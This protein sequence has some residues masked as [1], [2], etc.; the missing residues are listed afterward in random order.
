MDL[1]R[2]NSATQFYW[3]Y[4]FEFLFL[5]DIDICISFLDPQSRCSELI[6]INH[7]RFE[8]LPDIWRSRNDAYILTWFLNDPW[9]LFDERFL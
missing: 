8:Q 5:M 4:K 3:K 6:I 9:E 1:Q 7:L 2:E